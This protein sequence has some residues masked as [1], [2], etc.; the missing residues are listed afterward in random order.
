MPR[1]CLLSMSFL[2][3][4]TLLVRQ[5]SFPPHS[6][7]PSVSLTYDLSLFYQ[8]TT[9][10]LNGFYVFV[11][12]LFLQQGELLTFFGVFW[13]VFFLCS[14]LL[15]LLFWIRSIFPI[16][17]RDAAVRVRGEIDPLFC[18]A[19]PSFIGVSF[20]PENFFF[21]P[22]WIYFAVEASLRTRAASFPPLAPFFPPVRLCS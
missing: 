18:E 16:L 7:H 4:R 22:A 13:Q 14:K 12:F 20:C 1:Y 11:V 6:V 17:R 15:D 19:L 21:L 5:M 3:A 2:Q 10:L 9:A 8:L